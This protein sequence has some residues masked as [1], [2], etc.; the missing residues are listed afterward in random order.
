MA[1]YT[2][3]ITT[4]GA[5]PLYD[6]FMRVLYCNGG[7]LISVEECYSLGMFYLHFVVALVGIIILIIFSMI[8]ASILVELN[9]LSAIP[10]ASP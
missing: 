8:V 7:L 4:V 9:P 5:I 2:I 10:Y 3:L 6:V 1:T